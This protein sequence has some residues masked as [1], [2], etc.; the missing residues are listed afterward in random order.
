MEMDDPLILEVLDRL[1]GA[2][3]SGAVEN[4]VLGRC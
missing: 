4:L 2:T 3:V 1:D